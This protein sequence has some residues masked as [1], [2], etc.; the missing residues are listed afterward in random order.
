[1]PNSQRS[2]EVKRREAKVMENIAQTFNHDNPLYAKME[3][4]VKAAKLL[5][6]A[7]LSKG[8]AVSIHLDNKEEH[9][10]VKKAVERE[11]KSKAVPARTK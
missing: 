11:K 2:V 3:D 8:K 4:D 5:K 10:T 6:E 9:N 7:C 1:M